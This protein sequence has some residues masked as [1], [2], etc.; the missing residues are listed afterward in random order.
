MMVIAVSQWTWDVVLQC[1]YESIPLHLVPL[2]PQNNCNHNAQMKQRHCE[3]YIVNGY[4]FCYEI[5][6]KFA[7]FTVYS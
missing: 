3:G 4:N 7:W 6:A 5:S 2:D 1:N